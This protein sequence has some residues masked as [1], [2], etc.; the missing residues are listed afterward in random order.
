M[1]NE[2][3]RTPNFEMPEKFAIPDHSEFLRRDRANDCPQLN[4]EDSARF[5]STADSAAKSRLKPDFRAN[6]LKRQALEIFE[7]HGPLNPPEWAVLAGMYPIRSSYTYL[8]RLHRFGLLHRGRDY[9]GALLYSISERGCERLRWL[10][11]TN[12][13]QSSQNKKTETTYGASI[14]NAVK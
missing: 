5:C 10:Q 8:L 2:N 6:S 14:P 13:P 9:R 3:P 11:F 4:V 12:D 1:K 7:L